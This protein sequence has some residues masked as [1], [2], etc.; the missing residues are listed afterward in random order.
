[1]SRLFN[2]SGTP[3]E[4]VT[5]LFTQNTQWDLLTALVIILSIWAVLKII[6]ISTTHILDRIGKKT[7]IHYD[8]FPVKALR[9]I[10]SPFFIVIAIYFSLLTLHVNPV[11]MKAM[12][13]IMLIIVVFYVCKV[14]FVL[15][16]HALE[17]HKHKHRKE[18]EDDD[19]TPLTFVRFFTKIL[20][21]VIGSLFILANMGV[22]VT[23]LLAGL[24]IG[25]IAIAFA[26][27]RVLGDLFS[28]LS[29]YFDKPFKPGDYVT[30]DADS[31]T[32]QKVGI[33]STRIKTLQGQELTIPNSELA[34]ARINNYKRMDR[35]RIAFTIGVE[36]NTPRKKLEKIPDAI[37]D[38]VTK[39]EKATFD[40]AHLMSFGQSGINIDV[41]YFVESRQF[42]DYANIQQQINFE[43][44]KYFEVQKIK[45]AFPTQ[46]VHL[47]EHGK[48]KEK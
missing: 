11:L 7:N 5:D 17:V 39:H 29:I 30:V 15:L 32:V 43:I 2:I 20:L 3:F 37:K 1:M 19:E 18:D 4:P 26:L 21:A 8:G 25:G 40:R 6:R 35:R 42:I 13:L 47:F 23:S 27:Q 28:S 14:L 44:M 34:K 24:G 46:T 48:V 45:F 10:R 33:L 9:A 36:Y 31:G 12:E 41:V 16:D 38:I 22:N